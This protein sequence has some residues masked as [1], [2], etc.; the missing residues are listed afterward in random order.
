[1]RSELLTGICTRSCCS[2]SPGRCSDTATAAAHKKKPGRFPRRP[3]DGTLR[4][5]PAGDCR[6]P[7]RFPSSLAVSVRVRP[8]LPVSGSVLASSPPSPSRAS[9]RHLAGGIARTPTISSEMARV[10]Q[11]VRR[12]DL[13]R[14]SE[15]CRKRLRR[16]DLAVVMAR[17]G[18]V[19]RP[20]PG[21]VAGSGD[22]GS[23]QCSLNAA[24]EKD[25]AG[26][27][28]D[29][30]AGKKNARAISTTASRRNSSRLSSG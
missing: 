18:I 3:P 29:A 1:L 7:P 19:T 5:S 8:G 10:R 28:R 24:E 2:V 9:F 22:A 25:A 4:A 16:R 11:W 20:A 13:S 23:C 26:G 30:A 14:S 17:R 27:D 12:S 6:F 21:P 15:E